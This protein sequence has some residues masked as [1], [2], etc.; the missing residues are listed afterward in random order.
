MKEQ[1]EA[2]NKF[3]AVMDVDM[4]ESRTMPTRVIEPGNARRLSLFEEQEDDTLEQ[5]HNPQ[6]LQG[7]EVVLWTWPKRLRQGM[8]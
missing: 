1:V 3:D 6:G 7:K 2:I 5:L 8:V 4:V